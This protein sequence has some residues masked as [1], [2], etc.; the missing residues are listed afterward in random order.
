[1]INKHIKALR[2]YI[3]DP[4]A[5][6]NLKLSILEWMWDNKMTVSKPEQGDEQFQK[7]LEEFI[8]LIGARR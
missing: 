3:D 7:E 5:S 8:M 6:D 1:M 2:N 4:T